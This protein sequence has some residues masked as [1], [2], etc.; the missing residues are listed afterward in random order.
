MNRILVSFNIPA[1]Q[2]SSYMKQF[3]RWAKVFDDIWIVRTTKSHIEVRD[4]LKQKFPGSK[5]LTMDV[6]QSAWATL[7]ISDEVNKWLKN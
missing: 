7:N 1:D 3:P 2:V 5:I 6:T 4:D